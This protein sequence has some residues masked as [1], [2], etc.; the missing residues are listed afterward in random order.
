MAVSTIT[1]GGVIVV[2][3]YGFT[4]CPGATRAADEFLAGRPEQMLRLSGGGGF[5]VKGIRTAQ[6][7]AQKAA[8]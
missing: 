2:D 8:A 6:A 3:D 4:S 7:I 1:D 5:L